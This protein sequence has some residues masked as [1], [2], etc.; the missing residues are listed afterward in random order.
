LKLGAVNIPFARFF[1]MVGNGQQLS[2]KY[3]PHLCESVETYSSPELREWSSYWV[4]ARRFA[5]RLPVSSLGDYNW[6]LL[7]FL[8]VCF[9][10]IVENMLEFIKNTSHARADILGLTLPR[11]LEME[12][13]LG[14][15]A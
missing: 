7:M 15:C 9:V 8:Y 3:I 14:C 10:E 2:E 13:M 6:D 11:P 4:V 12:F 5:H 1:E